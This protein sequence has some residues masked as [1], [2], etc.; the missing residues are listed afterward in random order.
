MCVLPRSHPTGCFLNVGLS[1]G[2]TQKP[3]EKLNA[4]RSGLTYMKFGSPTLRKWNLD[5]KIDAPMKARARIL[6][7][8]KLHFRYVSPLLR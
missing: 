5:V 6:D 1:V 4:I 7:A 2:A 8:P 3:M